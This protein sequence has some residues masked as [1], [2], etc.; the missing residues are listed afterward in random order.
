MRY[1]SFY[2][3]WILNFVSYITQRYLH[4][5]ESKNENE[6]GNMVANQYLNPIKQSL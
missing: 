6:S 5:R 4:Q 1:K 2:I 3:I